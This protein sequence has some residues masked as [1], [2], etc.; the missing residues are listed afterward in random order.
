MNTKYGV[1]LFDDD[2][3][4]NSG[5]AARAGEQARYITGTGSLSSDTIWITNLGFRNFYDAQLRA[6][7]RFRDDSFFRIP[8]RNLMTELG[9]SEPDDRPEAAT[10]L[11][12]LAG[13]VMRVAARFGLQEVPR[14][15]ASGFHNLYFPPTSPRLSE[16]TQVIMENSA[17]SYVF[18]ERMGGERMDSD[19]HVSL[20][21]HRNRH[22]MDMLNLPV[23]SGPW[24]RAKPHELPSSVSEIAVSPRPAMARITLHSMDEVLAPIVA[25][26][27]KGH[28]GGGARREWVPQHELAFLDH[29]GEVEIHD[30]FLAERFVHQPLELVDFTMRDD[31]SMAT[32]IAMDSLWHAP[33]RTHDDRVARTPQAVWIQAADRILMIREI[34]RMLSQT[35][36]ISIA[37]YGHGRIN[38][39]APCPD[40]TR[41][42]DELAR[43]VCGSELIPPFNVGV[44]HVPRQRLNPQSPAWDVV[45]QMALRGARDHL[46]NTDRRILDRLRARAVHR[47]HARHG[48]SGA[49]RPSDPNNILATLGSMPEHAGIPEVLAEDEQA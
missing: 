19:I 23:P 48:D 5:W 9:L 14:S 44:P 22:A 29:F 41:V 2:R 38:L 39:F 11:A 17:Q 25:F 34:R 6:N 21:R 30:V 37:G 42:G 3:A 43:L 18:C 10:L 12:E 31:L 47:D 28:G 4:L 24:T 32:G 35:S 15:L 26:G 45:Q 16:E 33:C 40:P 1:V 7:P 46:F 27:A 20:S 13:S 36:G 8:L 49:S